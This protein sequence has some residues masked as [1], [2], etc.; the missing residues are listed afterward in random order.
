MSCSEW[1][2]MS[3]C[4]SEVGQSWSSDQSSFFTGNREWEKWLGSIGEREREIQVIWKWSN[5]WSYKAMYHPKSRVFVWVVINSSLL[6]VFKFIFDFDL[7]YKSS[8]IWTQVFSSFDGFLVFLTLN[9]LSLDCLSRRLL[10][11]MSV[12][13]SVCLSVYSTLPPSRF[14]TSHFTWSKSD[15][16]DS[17][18]PADE[19]CQRLYSTSFMIWFALLCFALVLRSVSETVSY[20]SHSSF[21][22]L[23]LQSS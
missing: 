13:T 4:L 21:L 10:I 17:T 22:F 9:S 23:P 11:L 16:R 19:V 3:L 15:L 6:S 7:T 18:Q 8:I 20:P 1:R 14:L 2:W 12:K 5:W